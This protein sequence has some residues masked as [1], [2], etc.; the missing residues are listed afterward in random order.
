MLAGYS[1]RFRPWVLAA[2]AVGCAAGVA[3]GQWQ[4]GRAEEKRAA[5]AAVERISVRGVFDARHTVLLDNKVR[6]KQ[7]GY[8]VLTPLRIAGSEDHILVNRGWIAAARTREVLPEIRTPGGIV[9]VEGVVQERLPRV[10]VRKGGAGKVR[11]TVE[12]PAFA[13]ETGLR[14]QP[15]FLEQHSAL[16]DGL[17]REWMPADA[18]IEKHESYALQWYSLAALA[19]VLGVVFSFR[20]S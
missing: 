12:I 6:H 16:D 14:L 19:G 15:R 3:L 13:A 18:G 17:L 10:L 5:G 8:E 1:L 2:A 7:A 11:Q 9:A 20:K 4:S